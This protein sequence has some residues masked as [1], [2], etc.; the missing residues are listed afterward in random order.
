M[1]TSIVLYI[2]L[3]FRR[4]LDFDVFCQAE[5]ETAY[6][7]IVINSGLQDPIGSLPGDIFGGQ[8]IFFQQEALCSDAKAQL[9]FFRGLPGH[10]EDI[11]ALAAVATFELPVLVKGLDFADAGDFENLVM[12]VAQI[13]SPDID[14][15]CREGEW[16]N[17]SV[18]HSFASSGFVVLEPDF[19]LILYGL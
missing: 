5:I 4:V 14:T 16:L 2:C 18:L 1:L 17:Q 8:R 6:T 11:S 3:Q 9:D 13:I 7:G 10:A 15:V 12:K 19:L